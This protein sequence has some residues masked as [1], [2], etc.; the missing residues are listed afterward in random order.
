MMGS[1]TRKTARTKD[2][3]IKGVNG[4]DWAGTKVQKGAVY[5]YILSI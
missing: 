5:S 3:K 4:A 1:D 2:G